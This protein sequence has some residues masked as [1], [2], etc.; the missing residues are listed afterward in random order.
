MTKDEASKKASAL[1]QAIEYL[2]SAYIAYDKTG[3]DQDSCRL[4]NAR[5]N[6]KNQLM[7][8]YGFPESPACGGRGTRH[9]RGGPQ[10]K[11]T[12]EECLGSGR[13]DR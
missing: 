5:V 6:V 4:H 13:V 10:D 3:D 1:G 2:I 11:W 9:G 12:C 7:A 8:S